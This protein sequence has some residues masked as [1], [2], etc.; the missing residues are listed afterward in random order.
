MTRTQAASAIRSHLAHKPAPALPC[1]HPD[2]GDHGCFTA[3][4]YPHAPPSVRLPVRLCAHG[5]DWP[6]ELAR[7]TGRGTRY[8]VG[9]CV[10]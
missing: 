10:G 6:L 8:A 3:P 5:L 4:A 2:L 1:A 7:A 9:V